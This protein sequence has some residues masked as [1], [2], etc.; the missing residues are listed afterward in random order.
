[1]HIDFAQSD[2]WSDDF[3]VDLKRTLG[4]WTVRLGDLDRDAITDHC[5][6]ISVR[7][8]AHRYLEQFPDDIT[9]RYQR[10]SGAATE[11]DRIMAGDGRYMLYGF[12]SSDNRR[13]AAYTILDLRVL[14]SWV[15]R[16]MT[17]NRGALPGKIHDGA[18]EDEARFLVLN[19][20]NVPAN[21]IVVR[22]GFAGAPDITRGRAA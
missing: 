20:R 15:Y 6:G 11:F 9:I 5:E 2:Q 10:P 3:L 22:R 18:A 12:P 21:A 8:R 19:R 13:L 7:I 4:A 1:M 16:F 14:R 17:A